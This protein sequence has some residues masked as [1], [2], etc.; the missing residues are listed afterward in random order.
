MYGNCVS[1]KENISRDNC[2]KEFK[3]LT[4]CARA[5]VSYSFE[6][7]KMSDRNDH[8]MMMP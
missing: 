7:E 6:R 3:A 1:S 8:G 5:A 4:D 2:L